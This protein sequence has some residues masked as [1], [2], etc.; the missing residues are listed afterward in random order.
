MASSVFH[1]NIP[2]FSNETGFIEKVRTLF[3][4]DEFH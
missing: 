4:E 3:E 1:R 2:Y